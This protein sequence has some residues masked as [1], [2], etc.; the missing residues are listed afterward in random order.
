[1]KTTIALTTWTEHPALIHAHR[2]VA[3][4]EY[5]QSLPAVEVDTF[6]Y[7]LPQLKTI[8]QWI[9]QVSPS[10]QFIVKA[11]QSMTRHPRSIIPDGM[12]LPEMFTRFRQV[13]QPM[14]ATD[15]LKTVLF[16]FPPQF[17]AEVKNIEYLMKV[18]ELMGDLPVAIELRNQSWY[19]P[20]VVQSLVGYCRDLHLTLVAADEPHQIQ[21]T[22]PFYLATTTPGLALIR[23]HGRNAQG[24]YHPGREWR[25]QRTRY[26][27][28]TAELQELVQQI[29]QLQPQPREL[30]V[31]FNNNSAG[32][33]APNALML[34]KM[35]NLHFTGLVPHDPEQL[36]LF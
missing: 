18:R 24:W 34:K 9:N 29:H 14:I 30:C 32:D 10:F 7:A 3:L 28:S 6:F 11:H 22:V 15:Q 1:M 5:A 19:R 8:Q 21:A 25:K 35:L 13:L 26:R 27:Y 12:D 16:Q 31:I 4:R 23:L 2:P 17:T 20:G 33:A 36:D